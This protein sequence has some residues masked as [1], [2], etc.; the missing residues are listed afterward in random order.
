MQHAAS[1]KR[2]YTQIIVV[3][4]CQNYRQLFL[5]FLFLTFFDYVSQYF[6]LKKILEPQTKLNELN[7][8]NL[9]AKLTA[10]NIF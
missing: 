7:I 1:G 2:Q 4:V 8:G 9:G 10:T 3:L 6:N 5:Y